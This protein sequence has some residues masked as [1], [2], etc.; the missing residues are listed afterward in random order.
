MAFTRTSVLRM[1]KGPRTCD[2]TGPGLGLPVGDPEVAGALDPIPR[3][4]VVGFEFALESA[5][6][7]DLVAR[8]DLLDP[9]LRGF[10]YEGATMAFTVL[11]ATAG[12]HRTKQLL[13]GHGRPHL[14]LAYIGIGF[15]MARLPRVLWP[16]V[17]PDLDLP[18][19][20]PWLSW[21]AVDGYG[22]D[23]AYFHRDRYVHGLERP[24]P[25]PWLGR[26]EYFSRAV[27][28]G[29]G[30]AIW[31]LERARP[32]AVAATVATFPVERRA[33]LWSGVALA[34]TVA[35]PGGDRLERLAR[36]AGDEYAD[37]LA[38]GACFAAKGRTSGGHVP[39]HTEQ[40]SRLFTGLGAVAAAD[41]A[42]ACAVTTE[43]T[44]LPAYEVWRT[45][46]RERLRHEHVPAS[47]A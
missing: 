19:Y 10:G 17:L 21:L 24:R 45:A 46:V 44:G 30:R 20:H 27:D 8:L 31:F 47:T 37:W 42:D 34:A 25:W 4:V 28:Q 26:P 13:E 43:D 7:D 29:V 5:D 35:G 22:F 32:E 18:P 14:F 9:A 33:D 1:V 39:E 41:V 16:R 15:A 38:V 23:L 2:V 3:A 6:V 36:I 12:T 40:A 11:D